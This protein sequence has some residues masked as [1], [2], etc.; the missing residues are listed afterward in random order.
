MR[1]FLR[2]IGGV[3]ALVAA[4]VGLIFAVLSTL[5]ASNPKWYE[6]LEK[7]LSP[8]V[9]V[10]VVLCE[11]WLG[12]LIVGSILVQLGIWRPKNES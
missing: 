6:L 7:L 9:L 11:I 1:K 4:F 10:G 2:T 3:A 12:V 8:A 5:A